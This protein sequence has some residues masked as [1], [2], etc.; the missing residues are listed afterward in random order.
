M[1]KWDRRSL[2]AAGDLNYLSHKVKCRE[3]PAVHSRVVKFWWTIVRIHPSTQWHPLKRKTYNHTLGLISE[4][5]SVVRN[6]QLKAGQFWVLSAWSSVERL[7]APA[8]A[9]SD[10]W[11]RQLGWLPSRPILLQLLQSFLLPASSDVIVTVSFTDGVG[12]A[13]TIYP[14]LWFMIL[15][16]I[17]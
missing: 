6:L 16:F 17:I 9:A 8:A 5:A 3:L 13:H 15:W 10:L 12:K 4:N 7:L 2:S 14:L 11:R 1:Q